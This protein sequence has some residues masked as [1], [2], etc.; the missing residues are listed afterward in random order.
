MF[1]FRRRTLLQLL[2]FGL[3][4][5]ASSLEAQEV[6]PDTAP[7]P[8][9]ILSKSEKAQLA[10]KPELKD[11]TSLALLLME[12][13]L[14]SAERYRSDEN[15]SLMYDELGGFHALMDNTLDFLL[16][17]SGQGG[18]SL[19]SLKKFEIG[20]RAYMPRIETLRREAPSN[21]EPYLKILLK[22]ISDAREKAITP[23]FGDSVIPNI[24][25]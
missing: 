25:N 10:D 9:K 20:L 23:F 8:L 17:S 7:P 22:Y 24:R 3:S 19:N 21:F 12:S 15:Y 16:R 5:S 2:I 1:L 14:R 18:K 11:H 4:V 6:L 13:R